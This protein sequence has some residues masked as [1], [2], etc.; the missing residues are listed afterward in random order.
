M[1][2]SSLPSAKPR[3]GVSAWLQLVR[4][5]NLFTVPGDPLAG[6]FLASSGITITA[7]VFHHAIVAMAASFMLYCAGLIHN[8]LCDYRE[9]LRERPTRPL[10][11]GQIKRWQAVIAFLLF[12][13][14]GIVLSYSLGKLTFGIASALIL[15][16]VLYNHGLKRLPAVGPVL[17]GICRGLSL[18]LGA[19][20]LGMEAMRTPLVIAPAVLTAAYIA[21]V[22]FIAT[23]ETTGGRMDW[24]RNLPATLLAFFY[25]LIIACSWSPTAKSLFSWPLVLVAAA[26]VLWAGRCAVSLGRTPAPMHVQ[27]GVGMLIRGL[28]LMQA[29]FCCLFG[30]PGLLAAAILVALMPLSG[31]VARHFYAS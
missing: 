10:P 31:F 13:H 24:R 3:T 14:G 1:N 8:D 19:S 29:S 6:F 21:C 11:S 15:A 18:V 2:D 20:S 30:T 22:T 5:P 25:T 23:G 27:L 7:G 9:D 17:M 28:L 12:L 4:V 16:I 26:A